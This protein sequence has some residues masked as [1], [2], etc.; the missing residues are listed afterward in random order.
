VRP[1]RTLAEAAERYVDEK[2]Y[3]KSIDSDISR[4]NV[5]L[6]IFGDK[7]IDELH[8]GV[9]NPWVKKRQKDGR[10]ANTI[11][12]GLKVIRQILNV[13]ADEWIDENGLSWL[14]KAPKIK[15]LPLDDVAEPYPLDWEEQDRLFDELAPHLHDM[16]SFAVNTGCRDQEICNLR[17]EW[18]QKFPHLNTSVFIIPKGRVKNKRPRLVVLN[19]DASQ[20][21]ESRR[22]IHDDYVFSYRGKPI[23]RMYNSGWMNA[24][25]RAGL[26]R[27]RVHDL[28]HTYGSR[29][30][31]MGVRFEDMQDLL[32][33][34]SRKIT[35][36]YSG[37]ELTNLIRASDTVCAD[38]NGN[39]P[40]LVI[41]RLSEY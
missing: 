11:N 12:H 35:M 21:V 32:G 16:A 38:E 31:S 23:K 25:K 1:K 17:W 14:L 24:R 36:H 30:R 41:L 20:L 3:K 39:R 22:G 7:Y 9:L 5:I 28:K 2:Q 8:M 37:L 15:L 10:K 27:V 19:R 29:L 6:P 40:E 4:L 26:L 13:A 18:E 33:H 34:K